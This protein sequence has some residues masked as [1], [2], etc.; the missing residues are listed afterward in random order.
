MLLLLFLEAIPD[1]KGWLS[2]HIPPPHAVPVAQQILLSQS[3]TVLPI[4]CLLLQS[5]V[6][7][8]DSCGICALG[9]LGLH[10]AGV[11]PLSILVGT[12]LMAILS[13]L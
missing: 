11:L 13:S 7:C 8:G 10:R 3:L 5:V 12:T 6:G 9:N 2:F 1:R 4:P